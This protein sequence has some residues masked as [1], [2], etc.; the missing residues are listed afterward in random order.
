V[1]GDGFVGSAGKLMGGRTEKTLRRGGYFAC[2]I[3]PR[4]SA[5]DSTICFLFPS[6]F[7]PGVLDCNVFKTRMDRIVRG[8]R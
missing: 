2:L 3:T 5:L 4:L 1:V 8:L 7:E 6:T